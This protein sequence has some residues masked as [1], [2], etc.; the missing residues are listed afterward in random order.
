MFLIRWVC[1]Q[2]ESSHPRFDH[3]KLVPFD[4]DHDPLSAA[5]NSFDVATAKPAIEGVN[6]RLEQNRTQL[7]RRFL[8]GHHL[9]ANDRQN[10]ATHRFNFG[11]LGQFG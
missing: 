2:D 4:F 1:K 3:Q 11:Q 5:A 6:P 9:A 7:T 10:A 8:G